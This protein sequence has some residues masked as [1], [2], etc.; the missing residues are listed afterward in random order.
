MTHI[1]NVDKQFYAY[2][3]NIC[4]MYWIVLNDLWRAFLWPYDL[5]LAPRVPP[6]PHQPSVSSTSD[7]QKDRE[8]GGKGAGEEPSH[9]LLWVTDEKSTIRTE[10]SSQI[11]NTA[12]HEW[13]MIWPEFGFRPFLKS[14]TRFLRPLEN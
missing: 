14:I 11:G 7:I 6:P 9:V 8:R 1:I 3:Y 12:K 13:Q 5:N 2:K 10:K 4:R